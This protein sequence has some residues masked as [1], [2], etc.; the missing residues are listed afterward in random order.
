MGKERVEKERQKRIERDL[1]REDGEEMGGGGGE[2]RNW[3]KQAR[4][5]KVSQG[6]SKGFSKV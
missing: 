4:F 1:E 2:E 5:S 3:E 6:F